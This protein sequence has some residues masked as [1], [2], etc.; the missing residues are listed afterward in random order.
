MIV[1]KEIK[2]TFMIDNDN[3]TD[4]QY[5]NQ[6]EQTFIITEDEIKEMIMDNHL[7]LNHKEDTIDIFDL[8]IINNDKYNR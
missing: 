3:M 2:I 1:K 7:G 8:K 5:E 4:E 6:Q